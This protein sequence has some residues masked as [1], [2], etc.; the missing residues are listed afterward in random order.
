MTPLQLMV[1]FFFKYSLDANCSCSD[2]KSSIW[3]VTN[4]LY[5]NPLI[6]FI[7]KHPSSVHV[8]RKVTIVDFLSK[9]QLCHV[10]LM[11]LHQQYL[12]HTL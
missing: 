10:G 7:S 6:D 1:D 12:N 8:L 11:G 3:E 2:T 9:A 4:K 5:L